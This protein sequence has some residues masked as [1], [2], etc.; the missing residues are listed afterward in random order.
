MTRPH[1]PD[2]GW[3]APLAGT[4]LILIGC[5]QLVYSTLAVAAALGIR[6]LGLFV[7]IVRGLGSLG[8]DKSGDPIV[9]SAMVIAQLGL[10]LAA[11]A[12]I[13]GVLM[14]RNHR[15]AFYFI[16]LFVAFS[17]MLACFHVVISWY[18]VAV[19]YTVIGLLFTVLSI[20]RWR[21]HSSLA[22]DAHSKKAMVGG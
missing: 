6:F 7:D 8:P 10:A 2:Q 1:F 16:V 19:I 15:L 11:F 14:L 20:S 5:C 21:L 3:I 18:A 9:Y 13:A 12:I 4:V 17:F 22:F